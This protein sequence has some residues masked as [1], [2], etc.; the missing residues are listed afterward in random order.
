MF[1]KIL[2]ANRGEIALRIIQSARAMGYPTVAVYSEADADAP[3]VAAADQSVCIGPAA[4]A[5]SY[6]NI[7]ALLEAARRTGA[8]AVHPGYGFLSERSDFVSACDRAGLTFIGP[9]T[10]AMALMGSKRQS[11]EAMAAAGVPTVPGFASES[12]DPKV[13]Q[14]AAE[15]IGYPIMIKASAGGGGRG[16]RLVDAPKGLAEGLE[17]ARS[18]AQQAFGDGELILEKAI[19]EPR[20]IEIQV[21]ADSHGN[22][23]HLG[24]RDCSVQRR[25]QKVV[26]EAPSPF[27]DEPMR[28]A[29]GEAAVKAAKA[30]DYRG[31][32]TVEFIVDP[33]GHF[34]FL[35]M[36]TRLQVEHPVTEMVTGLDL[37]ALQLQVAAGDPL[38]LTQEEVQIR[39]HAM[40]VRLYAE[41][42]DRD[43]QPQTGRIHRWQP[44]A[45]E[46]V[47][48]DAG[49][50]EGQLVS[51]HYDPMLAK[52]IASGPD[53]DSARRRLI[54]A[55]D[56]TLLFGVTHNGG[57]LRR[58]L[59]HPGFASG[60]ATTAFL[61]QNNLSGS[62]SDAQV[63]RE[64]LAVAA[65]LFF[66]RDLQRFRP[67]ADR[68]G[69]S[70][71]LPN[72]TPLWLQPA[73]QDPVR[74]E[75]VATR[76]GHLDVRDSEGAQSLAVIAED[77]GR[78]R[79][80]L[81]GV[82]Q[83]C[84]YHLDGGSL[85]LL[86]EGRSLVIH[87]RTQAPAK[88]DRVEDGSAIRASMDGALIALSVAVGDRV[89][90]GQTL[91]VL[92]AM[93][94][95]HP[96]AALCD[97]TVTEVLV[98]EGDQVGAD[99]LLITIEPDGSDSPEPEKH[100]EPEQP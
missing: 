35:E 87:D 31:A 94:M 17:R 16:M 73:E 37:V 47:R 64:T 91:A 97:G 92:E 89:S 77:H 69:W 71:S 11:K 62:G 93:K 90:H 65:L 54:R 2:I 98:S 38:P 15:E 41:D 58:I 70:N 80:A 61:Q 40:E 99:E 10:E 19:V 46:G 85:Y 12:T 59:A 66:Q 36:N 13:W 74:L 81:D 83:D 88:G 3:H 4:A 43:Y 68:A 52:V 45:G 49:I 51:P 14:K 50:R 60:E 67:F 25:H 5:E 57:F 79:Y 39:G 32:G 21:F 53:R 72:P 55:L 82:N 6:L 22:V 96:L 75:L 86:I 76:G 1:S 34:Y 44:P 9:P 95:E 8:D 84:H 78:L 18:E 33:E 42:P 26:E 24:E 28:Q 63:P 7:E 29:M 48:V 20:H 56:E 23:I 27:V 100:S 30:C